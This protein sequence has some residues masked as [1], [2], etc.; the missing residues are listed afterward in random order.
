MNAAA[1]PRLFL[2]DRDILD[3]AFVTRWQHRP[4]SFGEP[5]L[6]AEFPWEQWAPV[7]Y[8]TVLHHEGCWRMWYCGWTRHCPPRVCY[9]E[10]DDGVSWRK[11]ELDLHPFEGYR[12]TNIVL[13]S[14]SPD[15]LIDDLTVIHDPQDA[16]WPL[17]MLYFDSGGKGVVRGIYA[18]RSRDGIRWHG[19][20]QEPVLRW[21]DRFNA[22]PTRLENQYVIFGRTLDMLEEGRGRC[23]YRSVSSDL[24][25]WSP[26]EMVLARDEED[27]PDMEIYSLPTFPYAGLLFGGIERMHMAPD[28]L[29]TELTWSRDGGRAW[30]RFRSRE[31]FLSWTEAPAWRDTWVNLSA[32][33]PVRH[34]N[35]LWFYYSARG[36]AHRVAYPLNQGAIGL[37]V[38]RL[39]GF[40]SMRA[41]Q[42]PGWLVTRPFD[43][44]GGELQVN[45]D[46][47]L[48]DTSHPNYCHGE[49][50]VEVQTPEGMPIPGF[51]ASSCDPVCTNTFRDSDCSCRVTWQ[52][53]STA[54]LEQRPVRLRFALREAHLYSYRIRR[55]ESLVTS[56]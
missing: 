41:G 36:G 55:P 31:P 26:P 18:A 37:G 30:R 25:H 46:C 38:L 44:P 45:V 3:S 5:V 7:M 49:L 42:R 13:P 10:S 4:R 14:R 12:R 39:D 22:L 43:W 53:A 2:D 54:A 17:K 47:R 27:P 50:R 11:P 32:S 8:G 40:C 9:A 51:E 35:E 21:G 15:G 16:D 20:S 24:L 19:L 52:G 48:D 34:E 33:C 29:D 56:V 1:V 6:R 28:R 23:V